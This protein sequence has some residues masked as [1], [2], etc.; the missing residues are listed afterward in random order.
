MADKERGKRTLASM[1]AERVSAAQ[2]TRG[3]ELLSKLMT[4]VLRIGM[5]RIVRRK[6]RE[7]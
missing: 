2:T 3:R 7:R 1:N 4:D 5:R 6:N